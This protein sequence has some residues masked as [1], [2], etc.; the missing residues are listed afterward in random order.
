MKA[1]LKLD[2]GENL[3]WTVDSLGQ[4]MQNNVLFSGIFFLSILVM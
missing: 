4:L 2:W 3:P 1:N